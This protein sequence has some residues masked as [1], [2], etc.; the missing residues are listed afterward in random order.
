MT[1]YCSH[2]VAYVSPQTV[3][4][5]L[6]EPALVLPHCPSATSGCWQ[7]CRMLRL[8]QPPP[9]ST[10]AA[11]GELDTPEAEAFGCICF[12]F[13]IKKN[14][15]KQQKKIFKNFIYISCA[16]VGVCGDSAEE[17]SHKYL[18]KKEFKLANTVWHI[19]GGLDTAQHSS[20]PTLQH[21]EGK[22]A[23]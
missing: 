13:L 14:K 22:T 20:C 19:R 8:T 21:L 18:F 1:G 11:P 5:A 2:S 3:L 12:D 6:Q 16:C 4:K 10:T 15:K 7:D 17:V 9:W 23:K